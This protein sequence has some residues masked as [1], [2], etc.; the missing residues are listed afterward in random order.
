MN[1]KNRDI[2]FLIFPA[3]ALVVFGFAAKTRPP[4]LLLEAVTANPVAQLSH[5]REA[6]V[7]VHLT[8]R[9]QAPSM[10]QQFLAKPQLDI[11]L[12]KLVL[13]TDSGQEFVPDEKS[14][15]SFDSEGNQRYSVDLGCSLSAVPRSAKQVTLRVP[16]T[17]DNKIEFPFYVMVR[18]AGTPR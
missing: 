7:A 9:Y 6:G 8:V 2:A 5:K 3:V 12:N 13:V 4:A 14:N 18:G 10:L 17:V 11:D 15:S 1:A 16:I